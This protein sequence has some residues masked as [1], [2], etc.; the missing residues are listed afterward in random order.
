MTTP[1]LLSLLLAVSDAGA[2]KA[3]AP[4]AEAKSAEAKPAAAPAAQGTPAE[5]GD[6][7]K[8]LFQVV[9]CQ[10]GPLPENLDAKVVANYCKIQKPR[11][12]RFKE[13]W[14]TTAPKFLAG[15]HDPD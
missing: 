3:A 9:T 6:D 2:A 1:I 10:D 11:F 15:L 4:V 7:V 13:H 12:D 5:L 14:G 8:L